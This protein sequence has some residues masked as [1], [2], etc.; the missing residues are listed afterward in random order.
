MADGMP[1][2]ASKQDL[3]ACPECKRPTR[4]HTAIL[5]DTGEVRRIV[6]HHECDACGYKW[7][8]GN[9]SRRRHMAI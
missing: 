6:L 9:H 1:R 8:N 7:S 5:Y 3:V 2:M 4:I